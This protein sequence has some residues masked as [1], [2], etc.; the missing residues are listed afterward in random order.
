MKWRHSRLR[1]YILN[2]LWNYRFWLF[3]EK[4]YKEH[5]YEVTDKSLN[6]ENVDVTGKIKYNKKVIIKKRFAGYMYDG[7]LYLD[8]PGLRHTI[9]DETW[10]VWKK[11][12]L[13]K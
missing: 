3:A 11:K 5:R 10:Q 4:M 13:V 2:A 8:N 1:F 7:R 6:L 9:D 12:G